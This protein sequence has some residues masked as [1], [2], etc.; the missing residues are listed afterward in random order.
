MSEGFYITKAMADAAYAWI[1]QQAQL[2]GYGQFLSMA[3]RGQIEQ[4]AAQCFRVMLEAAPPDYLRGGVQSHASPAAE[5]PAA[6]PSVRRGG[7]RGPNPHTPVD[8]FPG[9]TE[10]PPGEASA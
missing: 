2:H 8:P 3:S 4:A 10:E 7:A 5:A 6:T 9:T 1:A